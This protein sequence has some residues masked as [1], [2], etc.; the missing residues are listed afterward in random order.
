M[1]TNELRKPKNE[2]LPKTMTKFNHL[3]I[4]PELFNV[5]DFSVID[6]F[7]CSL[8]SIRDM[9]IF[10][11]LYSEISPILFKCNEINLLT[12]IIL[13]N[14]EQ[15]QVVWNAHFFKFIMI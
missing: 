11:W 3:K 9:L 15:V 2:N 1:I 8:N 7:V 5:A 6:T 13:I 4:L 10:I 12:D 14:I